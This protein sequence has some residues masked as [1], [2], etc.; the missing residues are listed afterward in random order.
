MSQISNDPIIQLLKK[1][2]KDGEIAFIDF[3]VNNQEKIKELDNKKNSNPLYSFG[4]KYY[5]N[6]I[7]NNNKSII[8]DIK[9]NTL[10]HFFRINSW[11][12]LVDVI[13]LNNKMRQML[14]P[15]EYPNFDLFKI[16]VQSFKNIYNDQTSQT[17]L[18]F[19]SAVPNNYLIYILS[20][21]IKNSKTPYFHYYNILPSEHAELFK[22]LIEEDSKDYVKTLEKIKFSNLTC[23]ESWSITSYPV[24]YNKSKIYTLFTSYDGMGWYKV[25]SISLL[26]K[27]KNHP[28]VFCLDGGSSGIDR[29][30]NYDFFQNN[31][32]SRN[33]MLKYDEMIDHI[34]NNTTHKVIF[35]LD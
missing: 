17:M 18:H 24:Y 1:V 9:K 6:D 33:K 15:I 20:Q 31:Q 34:K 25:L 8:H 22:N 10:F 19:L 27:N 3:I 5:S 32:P 28:F 26:E 12:E 7:K 21:W 14:N 4:A 30:N 16:V 23:D 2:V 35:Q 13:L 11:K 29:K